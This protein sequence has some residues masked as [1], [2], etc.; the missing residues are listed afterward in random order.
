M[1]TPLPLPIPISAS[2]VTSY[3]CDTDM[4]TCVYVEKTPDDDLVRLQAK[5]IEIFTG[6]FNGVSHNAGFKENVTMITTDTIL[7]QNQKVIKIKANLNNITITLPL[8]NDNIGRRYSFIRIDN[9]PLN[10]VIIA[11]TLGEKLQNV[12]DEFVTLD[13][14]DHLSI[15]CVSEDE[16]WFICI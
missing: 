13:P 7:L 5:N 14:G 3:I 1:T 16:G 4:D 10:T 6:D 12:I 2:G 8:I 15:Q 11:P 9:T